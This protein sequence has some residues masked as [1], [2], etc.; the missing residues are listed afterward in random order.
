MEEV[1]RDEVSTLA[2]VLV[3]ALLRIDLDE[4]YADDGQRLLRDWDL[5]QPADGPGSAA[6]AYLNATW[7][8]LLAA[9]FH[10]ELPPST[11]PDGGPRWIQV[12]GGLLEQPDDPWWDDNATDRVE[13]RDDVLR[14]AMLEA[15][16]ELVRRQAQDAER[17]TW[18]HQHLLR[19]TS[20]GLLG[21]GAALGL[22][23]RVVEPDPW[24][25]GGG[26][27][28]VDTTSWDP[29]LGFEVTTGPSMRMVLSLA[30]W[31]DSRWVALTGVSGHPASDHY[32]DQTDL[33]VEGESLPFPFT[34]EAVAAA[35][36]DELT[37]LPAP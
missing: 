29:V 23:R 11:W 32:T 31:D 15:R 16:D 10:D 33:L 26:P 37:L 19:L 36:E 21:D 4:G 35:A 25:V 22:A 1:Q 5:D 30:D 17:W 18:G 28:S 7:R 24:P 9:T 27:G 20:P 13:R 12:V 34:P 8:E 2:P 3:P 14:A 6:A